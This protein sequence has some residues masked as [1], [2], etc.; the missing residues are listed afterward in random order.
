MLFKGKGIRK[1]MGS[2]ARAAVKP[3]DLV[4]SRLH[5]SNLGNTS[6][7]RHFDNPTDHFV[8]CYS[9]FHHTSSVITTV[10]SMSPIWNH[11][12]LLRRLAHSIQRS[13]ERISKLARFLQPNAEPDQI[14]LN[15][16][17][18]S[19]S[20]VSIIHINIAH[21]IKDL[22]NPALHSAPG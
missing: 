18:R 22:P 20:K 21:G 10:S 3:K 12:T 16:P 6:E 4:H 11:G 15:I 9:L 14:G 5:L 7:F 1:A 13:S 19:L 2:A 17:L 8:I